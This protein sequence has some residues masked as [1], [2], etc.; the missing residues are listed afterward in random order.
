MR[1]TWE[2]THQFRG[3]TGALAW[4]RIAVYRG[5]DGSVVVICS[6]Q[7]DNPGT[8]VTNYAEHLARELWERE[9][10]PLLYS[11]IEH[12]PAEARP[13][14]GESYD[15]VTFQ[16]AGDE[17]DDVIWRPR[18]RAAVEKLLQSDG[19]HDHAEW[20]S[21]RAAGLVLHCIRCSCPL[22]ASEVIAGSQMC[23]RCT[24][25]SYPI[26]DQP[27]PILAQTRAENQ[28]RINAHEQQLGLSLRQ[29]AQLVPAL[30]GPR[31]L[32]SLTGEEWSA[33]ADQVEA[34]PTA[35]AVQAVIEQAAA[36]DV[37]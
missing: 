27:D 34:F 4:C 14:H 30:I 23:M 11:W 10:R 16:V 7:P 3:L 19:S 37:S 28:A 33:L 8:S 31:S 26:L 15:L 24:A 22:G 32:W 12:Y 25:P 5:E 2:G 6:E 36:E 21:L 29:R 17:F 9:N 20:Q 13:N 1:K 35:S 18:T